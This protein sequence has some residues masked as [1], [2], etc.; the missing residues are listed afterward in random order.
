[1][2][3][4][5]VFLIILTIRLSAFA[6]IK[7]EQ[8]MI[9]FNYKQHPLHSILNDIKNNSGVNF[10]YNDEFIKD[11]FVTCNVINLPIEN[12]IN[13]VLNV[14]DLNYKKFNGNC[15][16]LFRK[17]KK[18]KKPYGTIVKQQ[19]EM[20]NFSS[21]NIITNPELI[22]KGDPF[23]PALALKDNLEGKVG[24]KLLISKDGRVVKSIVEKTSGY[25]VLD[26][27]AAEYCR[28]LEFKPAI[29]N[30]Q[31]INIW[32]YMVFSYKLE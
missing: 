19:T 10:V 27:A 3:Y 13:K 9:T 18:V 24:M 14:S 15:Y 32:L 11:K 5:G 7:F 26:N 8:G 20:N 21:E 31:P 1:M 17:I 25:S 4:K 16:V 2:S 6:Q 23:Y 29:V 22:S 12:A 28:K 30:N